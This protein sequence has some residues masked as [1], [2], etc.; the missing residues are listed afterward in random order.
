MPYVS[1]NGTFNFGPMIQAEDNKVNPFITA[2]AGIYMWYFSEN[3]RTNK[4]S[5]PVDTTEEF[6]ASSLGIN[7]GG[8][9]E[10]FAMENLSV[11][12]RVNYHLVLMKDED[13]FGADFDNQ[14]FLTFGAGISCYFN[15]KTE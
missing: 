4:L 10:Y 2:G 8:G 7:V 1:L 3:E 6:K 12:G 9:V 14:G 11:F 5:A 15:M 13:R